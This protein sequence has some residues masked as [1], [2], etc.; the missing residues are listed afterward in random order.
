MRTQSLRSAPPIPRRSTFLE[1][2]ILNDFLSNLADE[3]PLILILEDL[4]S[5]TVAELKELAK[6]KN[7]AGYTTMKKAEL[8]EVLK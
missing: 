6:A 4:S 7:I 3:F 1:N 5:K 8:L 2:F